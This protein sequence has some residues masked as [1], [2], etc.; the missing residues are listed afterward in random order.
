[1][2]KIAFRFLVT[3]CAFAATAVSTPSI[4]SAAAADSPA[5]L[6]PA[7]I[8]PAPLTMAPGQ[9]APVQEPTRGV[10]KPESAGGQSAKQTTKP[11]S[12]Q[13]AN[14]ATS[15][16]R[17]PSDSPANQA[18]SL[19]SSSA[20]PATSD[21][22]P[23]ISDE[24]PTG[25]PSVESPSGETTPNAT[26]TT[27]TQRE[28][29]PNGAVRIEREVRRLDNGKLIHHG[30]WKWQDASG[31]L[32]AA[33]NFDHG[34]RQ[35]HWTRLHFREE[36]DVFKDAAYDGFASPFTSDAMF[37][38]G[39]MHGLW[40]LRDFEGRPIVSIQYRNGVRHGTA[41]W[42]YAN[43]KKLQQI[44]Y[45]DGL[46]DGEVIKWSVTGDETVRRSLHAGR[47]LVVASKKYPGGHRKSSVTVLTAPL[48]PAGE[49][50]WWTGERTLYQVDGQ[51]ARQGITVLWYPNGQTQRHGDFDRDMPVSTHTWWHA[52]GNR[53]TQGDYRLGRM[54]GPWTWWHA[55]GQELAK[56]E[57]HDGVP[58][59]TWQWRSVE[60]AVI[61]RGPATPYEGFAQADQDAPPIAPVAQAK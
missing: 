33:G 32:M 49:D 36:S 48:V 8:E 34:L 27:E 45:V 12:K 60:G 56:G 39:K 30:M 2:R 29:H 35:G 47:E 24:S 61:A 4:R 14:S 1:M 41:T 53:Q 18:V 5:P 23:R 7:A 10:G 21:V 3:A 6:R 38:A 44:E 28:L 58:V 11:A 26:P 43:G 17:Q 51:D 57:F 13:T 50:D 54:H 40:T 9:A 52:N 20:I 55:N 19:R 15:S 31:R 16:R 42:W 46:M 22:E 25:A 37:D 59:G